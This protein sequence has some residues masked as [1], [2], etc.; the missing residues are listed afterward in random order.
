MNY[1]CSVGATVQHE[2]STQRKF[3]DYFPTSLEN[4]SQTFDIVNK[5]VSFWNY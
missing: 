3:K 2:F 1:C 4:Y 5:H